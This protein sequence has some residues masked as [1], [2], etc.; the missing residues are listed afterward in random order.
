MPKEFEL[1]LQVHLTN[2]YLK[3]QISDE[4][5]DDFQELLDVIFELESRQE[6]LNYKAIVKQLMI[7]NNN[8]IKTEVAVRNCFARNKIKIMKA[9]QND[10]RYQGLKIRDL[11][12][13]NISR[14]IETY[15]L[16]DCDQEILG[17]ALQNIDREI[18]QLIIHKRYIR[19]EQRERLLKIRNSIDDI[20]Q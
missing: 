9:I 1:R 20:L 3:Q 14:M 2:E 6:T 12:L 10:P 19:H 13:K 11:T 17:Y 5:S 8:Y 4:L 18:N 15:I 16:S 7:R